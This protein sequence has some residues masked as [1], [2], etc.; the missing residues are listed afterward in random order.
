MSEERALQFRL[1]CLL[2]NQLMVANDKT[3]A[4]AYTHRATNDT[5]IVLL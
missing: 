3:N 5:V 1:F 4:Q 2:L